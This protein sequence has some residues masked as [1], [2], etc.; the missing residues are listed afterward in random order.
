MVDSLGV[1]PP[2]VNRLWGTLWCGLR[3]VGLGTKGK[4]RGFT[5]LNLLCRLEVCWSWPGLSNSSEASSKHYSL[6][7]PSASATRLI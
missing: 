2:G 1:G 7:T 6:P 3:Y 4:G 5:L